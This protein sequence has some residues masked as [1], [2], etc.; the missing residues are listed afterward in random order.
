M[1][2]ETLPEHQKQDSRFQST[3]PMR[4]ETNETE[5]DITGYEFQSTL[6]MRGETSLYSQIY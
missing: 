1:R 4:G 6:P 3:L 5:T 2:G